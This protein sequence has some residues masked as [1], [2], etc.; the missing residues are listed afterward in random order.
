MAV[1]TIRTPFDT[2]GRMF[3]WTGSWKGIGI[4]KELLCGEGELEVHL[5][6]DG[7]VYKIDKAKAR[8]L[9]V[10]YKSVYQAKGTKLVVVPIDEFKKDAKT[11]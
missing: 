7:G 8:D 10:K 1:I 5:Q 11:V 4:K 6:S 9:V 2:A 3:G